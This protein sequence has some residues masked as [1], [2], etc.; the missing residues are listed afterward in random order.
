M[1]GIADSR[2]DLFRN[3]QFRLAV[4]FTNHFKSQAFGK[5]GVLVPAAESFNLGRPLAYD[6]N[7][8]AGR[9][10]FIGR[11]KDQGKFP[12]FAARIQGVHFRKHL[13]KA[14]SVEHNTAKKK[15]GRRSGK[16]K[17][18][19]EQK[20]RRGTR[21]GTP[22]IKSRWLSDQPFISEGI[23]TIGGD[24]QVIQ[25][26]NIQQFAALN[27]LFGQVDIGF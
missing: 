21:S 5:N 13:C 23:I 24:D 25:D 7:I 3:S 26:G 11:D 12:G 10:C 20:N 9:Q 1:I 14:Y 27:Q 2:I 6:V 15:T 4:M 18:D 22:T 19:N 8:S 16:D 17:S